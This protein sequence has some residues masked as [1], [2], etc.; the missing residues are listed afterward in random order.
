MRVFVNTRW[1]PS[2]QATVSV[3]NHG[4]LYGDGVFET[5]RAYKGV[6]FRLE[7][8]LLRLQQSARLVRMKIPYSSKRL[9]SILYKTLAANRL[10][11]GMLRLTLSRGA[12]EWGLDPELRN[13]PT[14]VVMARP[15]TRYP[16]SLY[17]RGQKI[18]VVSIRRLGADSLDPRIKSTNFLNNIL[19]RI[20]ARRA[21]ADEGL[22]LNHEGYLTEGTISNLFMVKNHRLFTP[23]PKAGLLEGITRQVVLELADSSGIPTEEALLTPDDLFRADEC[24][25]TNTSM[26]IMPVRKV[27]K[28]LIG[29]GRPGPI[30]TKLRK[31]FRELVQEECKVH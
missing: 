27:G 17:A 14:L 1:V 19:A 5:V 28:A 26:E 11:E 24:F 31:A 23:S 4:F 12:G 3:Y 2:R 22:M 6:V 8:H 9:R 20:E 10:K 7:E 29:K 15:L 16:E 30:T 13:R 18:T 21:G 25:L